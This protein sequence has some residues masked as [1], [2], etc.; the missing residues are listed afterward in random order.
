MVDRFISSYCTRYLLQFFFY[1]II[2]SSCAVKNNLYVYDPFPVEKGDFNFYAGIGSGIRASADVVDDNGDIIFNEHLDMAPNLAVGAQINLVHNLDLRLAM[3]FPYVIGGFGLRAGPQFSFFNRESRF[4]M[5]LGTDL[6]FVVA[7]D[8]LNVLDS[9]IPLDITVNSIIYADF[10]LPIGYQLNENTKIVL[11]PRY[12]LNTYF[13]R[14]RTDSKDS[15]KFNP[16]V[17]SIALGLHHKK[18]YLEFSAFQYKDELYPN[19]GIVYL[20]GDK[21][22]NSGDSEF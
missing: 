6:G 17:P 22:I 8:S 11:T 20:L 1:I 7:K 4:N 18:V 19:F 15:Y 14:Y 2:F 5:A 3:H 10:F 13:I 16:R 21:P 12:S 9:S